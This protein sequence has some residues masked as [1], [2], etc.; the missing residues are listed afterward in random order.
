MKKLLVLAL[1]SMI[2][3]SSIFANGQVEKEEIPTIKWVQI[4]NGMPTNYDE[5]EAQ[6]NAYLEEKLGIH[7]EMEVLSW[8]DFKTRRSVMINTNEDYDIM[9][10]SQDT[11]VN[12][13]TIGAFAD[14]SDKVKT[15]SPDLYNLMPEAYWKAVSIDGKVYGVPTYKDSSMTNY[16]VVRQGLI[17]KYNLDVK[18]FMSYKDVTPL[19]RTIKEGEHVSPYVLAS[20]AQDPSLELYDTIGSGLPEIGVKIDDSSMKVVSVYEQDD[21]MN[22]FRTLHQWYQEGLINSDASTLA[23]TP[24]NLPFKVS[25]GWKTAAITVWGPQMGEPAAAFQKSKTI[26]TNDTVRG[27]INCINANSKY[28]DESLKL[29]QL[30]NTD[31]KL[32]DMLA[33]GVEGKDYEYTANNEIHR[34]DTSWPM[35]QYSQGTFFNVSPLEGVTVDQWAEVKQLNQNAIPSVM[36]G[37][38]MN[39]ESVE[40][41]IANCNAIHEKYK[42]Q[43][44]TGT[45]DPDVAVAAMMKEMRAAGFDKILAEAQKQVNEFASK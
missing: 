38:T 30:V 17:D 37:F 43:I 24:R 25:Q 3:V 26:L 6:V 42:L 40:D 39:T 41:E 32:R 28:I 5:W 44:L 13:V 35:A 19:L 1:A 33:F 22:I 21:M 18:D 2:A 14:I 16:W 34:I 7:M 8:G 31:T 29:L 36:L 23:E 10:T 11:F 15:V 20:D 45:S 12:D 9:F 4:G 27:S